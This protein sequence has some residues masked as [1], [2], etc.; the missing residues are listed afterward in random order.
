MMGAPNDRPDFHFS[1][2]K[3]LSTSMAFPETPSALQGLLE[4]AQAAAKQ[5][6]NPYSKFSVGCALLTK[7]GEIYTG[8][9]IENASYSVTLCAERV[10]AAQAVHVKDMEWEAMVVVSPE[11]VSLCGVCRQFLHEFAPA[12]QI[13]VG[14]LEGNDMIGPV[15]LDHLLPSA[16]TLEKLIP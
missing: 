13:W 15:T 4:R 8:S 1:N 10:A 7:S 12:L 5:A 2:D 6:Y 11:R 14:Y 3:G 9:N 16:M